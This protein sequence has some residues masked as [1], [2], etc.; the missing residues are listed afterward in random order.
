MSSELFLGS[1]NEKQSFS[2]G[3]APASLAYGI[4]GL[5][6]TVST[7]SSTLRSNDLQVLQVN[8][9][10]KPLIRC[11]TTHNLNVVT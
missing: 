7:T 11:N 8:N 3:T 5:D 10:G 6:M 9:K 4:T 1:V 2:L